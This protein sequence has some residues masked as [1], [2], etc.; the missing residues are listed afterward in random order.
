VTRRFPESRP[1][2]GLRG[3]NGPVTHDP[4][5]RDEAGRALY[6][7]RSTLLPG[8][9]HPPALPWAELDETVRERWRRQA[10]AS[11]P[12]RDTSGMPRGQ[13]RARAPH[14]AER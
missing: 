8:L 3:H 6:A 14:R 13:E 12:V 11:A 2:R 4:V 9:G 5:T 1:A 7:E 10:E